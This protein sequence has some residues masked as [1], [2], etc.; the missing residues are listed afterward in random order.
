MFSIRKATT[1]DCELIHSLA[2]QVFPQTYEEILAPEQVDFMM[3][4][5][6]A[7]GNIRKQ[8]EEEGHV[9]FLAYEECEACG[10]VSIQPEGEH[11]F[12]LQK[13]YVL[14]YFQGNRAGRAL[15][16][17]ALNYIKKVHPGPCT[18]ELNVNRHNTKAIAVYEHFG[19]R[20]VREGDFDIGNGFFMNDYIMGIDL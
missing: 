8:M 11:L 14:P 2:L 1:A 10:Y 6:Y 19:M 5:M 15:F 17:H 4:W 16:D 12:H 20:K 13:I 7:P 18:V 3:E 9:Y